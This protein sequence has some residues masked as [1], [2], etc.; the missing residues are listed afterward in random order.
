MRERPNYGMTG[1]RNELSDF[2]LATGGVGRKV[3][4][5]LPPN[6]LDKF[7]IANL[8]FSGLLLPGRA[9]KLRRY[10]CGIMAVTVCS[11]KLL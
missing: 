2:H 10:F 6:K 1:L 5:F 11:Y 4:M 9:R 3:E 8:W 7:Y